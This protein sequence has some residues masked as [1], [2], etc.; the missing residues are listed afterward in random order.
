V[1]LP[2]LKSLLARAAGIFLCAHAEACLDPVF[3]PVNRLWA[4]PKH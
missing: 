3:N 1:G 2:V 4:L